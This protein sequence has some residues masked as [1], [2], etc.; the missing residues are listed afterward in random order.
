MLKKSMVFFK[1]KTEVSML[2][3]KIK[4]VICIIKS[5]YL[6]KKHREKASLYALP[7]YILMGPSAAGKTSLLRNSGLNFLFSQ[8]EDLRV[9]GL[10]G[11]RQCDWWFSNEAILLD[12]A[13]YYMT[14]EANTEEWQ[15]LIYLLKKHRKRQPINGII[16][17]LNL[18]D[19]L[20]KDFWG[21]QQ[22]IAVIRQKIDEMNRCFNLILPVFF[23]VTK[24]DCLSGFVEFFSEEEDKFLD[25]VLGVTASSAE[26]AENFSQYFSAC[27]DDLIVR[28]EFLKLKKIAQEKDF[29]KK[30]KLYLFSEIYSVALFKINEFLEMFCKENPYQKSLKIMGLYMISSGELSNKRKVFI[31][32]Q[33][34]EILEICEEQKEIDNKRGF[35][36]KNIFYNIIFI[37]KD[38]GLFFNNPI[39]SERISRYILIS[40]CFFVFIFMFFYLSISFSSNSVLVQHVSSVVSDLS[41]YTERSTNSYSTQWGNLLY[42]YRYYQYL[43]ENKA[44]IPWYFRLGFYRGN[45]FIESISDVIFKT[46]NNNFS[47]KIKYYFEDE[48]RK[49]AEYWASSDSLEREK[50]RGDY[51][52]LLKAYLMMS[53]PKRLNIEEEAL[54]LSGFWVKI[55]VEKIDSTDVDGMLKI[56]FQHIKNGMIIN[57]KPK[58]EIVNIARKNLDLPTNVPNLFAL[59]KAE[60][61]IK[62]RFLNIQDFVSKNDIVFFNNQIALPG[63]YTATAWTTVVQPMI[64]RIVNETYLGDWVLMGDIKENKNRVRS[65]ELASRIKHDYFTAYNAAWLT[66][67]SSIS[68][69]SFLSLKDAEQKLEVLSNP[70]GI[71]HDLLKSII[72]NTILSDSESENGKVSDIDLPLKNIDQLF[73]KESDVR[74]YYQAIFNVKTEFQRLLASQDLSRELQQYSKAILSGKGDDLALYKSA[75]KIEAL[76]ENIKDITIQKIMEH[77]LLSPLSEV[78]QFMMNSSVLNIQKKWIDQV[79]PTYNQAINDK[80]PFVHS[81]IEANFD[82]VG[83]FFRPELGV[84]PMFIKNYLDSYLELKNQRWVKKEWLSIGP[85]FSDQFLNSVNQ[86]WSIGQVLF[87]NNAVGEKAI[88]SFYPLPTP[89]VSQIVVNIG[90]DNYRYYNGPQEWHTFSFD[91]NDLNQNVSLHILTESN[92]LINGYNYSGIW[93][94]FYLLSKARFEQMNPAVGRACWD[95]VS[96]QQ[97]HYFICFL[98]KTDDPNNII[99]N[100]VINPFHLEPNILAGNIL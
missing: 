94:I 34:K 65:S 93:G 25:Q 54:I 11:T 43:K 39:L 51:Y 83:S 56:Y 53:S 62:C 98:V 10:G 85:N 73:S 28:L 12:T 67:L 38:A 52:M 23:I 49:Y 22:Y 71:I 58:T 44:D 86:A 9:R 8:S 88:F 90:A 42:S 36:I 18:S 5:S 60:S 6:G 82:E 97:H 95:L 27:R 7:W 13:G 59:V 57:F 69:D 75:I 68:L 99:Q 92:E 46:I 32:N 33:S 96:S 30:Q 74:E 91:K 14:E 55:F 31:I 4:E 81:T 15:E 29:N 61:M 47:P 78:W 41:W 21:K 2:K 72:L 76:C 48:L 84:L 50:I 66:F 1:K 35:F 20:N 17:V 16:I 100:M 26:K 79:I 37:Y 87:Q 70:D 19:I 77:I 80:F 24:M 89:G 64:N 40:V 45:D 63:M 3:K